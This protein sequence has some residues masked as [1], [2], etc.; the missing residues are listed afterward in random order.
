MH[1]KEQ[2]GSESLLSD[3]S[4]HWVGLW[5]LFLGHFIDCVILGRFWVC[6]R[7][8]LEMILPQQLL[9][10]YCNLSQMN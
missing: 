1:L 10:P 7:E 2:R 3:N 8:L 6:Q 9:F 4:V 5:Q